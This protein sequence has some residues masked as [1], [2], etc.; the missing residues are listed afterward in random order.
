MRPVNPMQ[1]FMIPRRIL[2]ACFLPCLY[3]A[4][5]DGAALYKSRCATCH[6]GKPQA[7]M[8]LRDELAQKTPEFVYKTMFEGAMMV[9]ASGLSAEEGR[10]IARFITG[11]EFSASTTPAMTGFC[12]AS[13]P[14]FSLKDGDWSG[15]GLD[16]D[17]SHFQIK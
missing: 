11:Q 9:Q 6:D 7:R 10:A 4:P 1:V 16:S 17:N 3:A 5:P 13:P 12:S 2:I 14:A 15:W 8:P